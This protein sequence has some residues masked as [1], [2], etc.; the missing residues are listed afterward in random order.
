MYLLERPM[1]GGMGFFVLVIGA[2]LEFV[3]WNLEFKFSLLPDLL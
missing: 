3:I 1:K 2:S